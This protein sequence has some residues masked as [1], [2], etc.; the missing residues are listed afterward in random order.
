MN[1]GLIRYGGMGSRP[2]VGSPRRVR[3]S[4]RVTIQ[5]TIDAYSGEDW[6]HA[7]ELLERFLDEYP[8]DVPARIF[9]ERCGEMS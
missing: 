6:G 9:L 5:E 8:E 3:I 2:P 1:R 7:A 4:L